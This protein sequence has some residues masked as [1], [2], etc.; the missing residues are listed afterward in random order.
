[1]LSKTEGKLSEKMLLKK[2]NETQV[3]FNPG[4]RLNWPSNNWAQEKK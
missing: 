4:L 1:M 3:K 2:E